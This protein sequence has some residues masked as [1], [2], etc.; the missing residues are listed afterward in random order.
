MV[1]VMTDGGIWTWP[2]TGMA[3]RF[4]HEVHTKTLMNPHLLAIGDNLRGHKSTIQVFATTGYRVEIAE[5]VATSDCNLPAG[6]GGTNT[7][8]NNWN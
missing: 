2:S 6:G 4:D 7:D 3:Y 5:E 8:M 1:R